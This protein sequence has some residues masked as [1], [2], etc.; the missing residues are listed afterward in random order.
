LRHVDHVPATPMDCRSVIV[1]E[2]MVIK[3]RA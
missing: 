3:Q 1:G 2:A